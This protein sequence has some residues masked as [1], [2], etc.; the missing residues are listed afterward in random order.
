MELRT[1]ELP[2][3]KWITEARRWFG[4]RGVYLQPT[5]TRGSFEVGKGIRWADFPRPGSIHYELSW[6]ET[7]QDA[8]AH[9][10]EVRSF[11]NIKG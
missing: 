6:H 8:L 3:G 7:E 4:W 10:N 9:L 5:F 1:R 2:N 11:F